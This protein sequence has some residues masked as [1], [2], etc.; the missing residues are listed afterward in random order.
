MEN[1]TGYRFTGPQNQSVVPDALSLGVNQARSSLQTVHISPVAP[2]YPLPGPA[3][4]LEP[5]Q[6]GGTAASTQPEAPAESTSSSLYKPLFMNVPFVNHPIQLDDKGLPQ[7][8]GDPS[9][10]LMDTTGIG[11]HPLLPNA[12]RS[13]DGNIH[14]KGIDTS[15]PENS[16]WDV[17]FDPRGP[18]LTLLL[19]HFSLASTPT[20][21][22]STHQSLMPPGLSALLLPIQVM[23]VF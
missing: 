3:S 13:L 9:W 20:S 18:H 21:P 17:S 1:Q 22:L 7:A 10:M 6:D 11:E 4:T 23:I 16:D 15:H 14:K 2:G 12:Y 8:D 19:V 5:S